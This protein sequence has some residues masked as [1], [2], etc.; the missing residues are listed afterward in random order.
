MTDRDPGG[1]RRRRA[2]RGSTPGPPAR[3][4][5]QERSWLEDDD[6]VADRSADFGADLVNLGFLRAA[7]R[8]SRR[9]WAGM[10]VFGLLLGAAFWVTHSPAPEAT[11]TLLL[12]VGPEGQPGT[13]ILNDQAMAD[14]RGTATIA[15]RELR[16]QQSV[17]SFMA[18]YKTKVVTDR[19]LSISATAASSGQAVRHADAVAKAFLAFRRDQL[20]VQQQ[21]D[22]AA[23]DGALTLSQQRIESLQTRVSEAQPSSD[24][25]AQLNAD[26]LQAESE[27]N[28][29]ND[30][31]KTS[32]AAS[33][34][35]TAAMIGQS[36]VL[37][38]A[39]PVA[40]PRFKP[41]IL[42]C[43]A[44]LILGLVVG[45]GIV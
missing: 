4:D 1:R 41:L 20:R 40:H 34:E 25:K 28:V 42:F 7:L 29:L 13:A 30:Q 44:G 33:Q 19:I 12:T 31:V 45:V 17:D 35:T 23:L 22:F 36:K 6:G 32:K 21:Q 14:S 10:A 3:D 5:A 24:S 15:L 9:V 43:G 2:P 8:R 11:T 27:S 38:T 26:L 16:L 39:S 18:T 37:D